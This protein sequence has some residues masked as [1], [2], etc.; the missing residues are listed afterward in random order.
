[1]CGAVRYE[2]TSAPIAMFRCHCRDCQRVSGGPYSAVALVPASAFRLTKGALQYHSTGSL[3]GGL[4]QRSF[5]AECGSR[6]TGSPSEK[7]GILAGSL[8][9]PSWFRPTMEM[10]VCDTQPWD[11]LDE[12]LPHHAQ[13]PSAS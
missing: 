9:D 5:C 1:M 11:A 7:V 3:R 10:F 4:H 6:I 2:C 13:Y 12:N 8:D